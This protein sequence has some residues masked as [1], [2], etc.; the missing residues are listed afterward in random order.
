MRKANYKIVLK[1][2]RIHQLKQDTLHPG[3]KKIEEVAFVHQKLFEEQRE[4]KWKNYKIAE[5]RCIYLDIIQNFRN[6]KTYDCSQE[7]N[8]IWLFDCARYYFNPIT[9]YANRT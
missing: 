7:K 1:K 6:R 5:S 9:F 3:I 8:N 2:K 4:K